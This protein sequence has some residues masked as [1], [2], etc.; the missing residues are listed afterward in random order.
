MNLEF[1]CFYHPVE[2][3]PW[4]DREDRGW[5]PLPQQ[6]SSR[7]LAL[8][9]VR[10]APRAVPGLCRRHRG[11]RLFISDFRFKCK[12]F[13]PIASHRPHPTAL[14]KHPTLNT[15]TATIHTLENLLTHSSNGRMIGHIFE[16][17]ILMHGRSCGYRGPFRLCRAPGRT[18]PKPHHT[19]RREVR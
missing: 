4:R 9:S 12:P 16:E 2:V 14:C 3:P 8:L 15:Q 18:G 10:L 7:R 6:A 13:P 5:K 19:P 11:C 1:C 17:E